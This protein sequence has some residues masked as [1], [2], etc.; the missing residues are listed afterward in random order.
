MWDI[1]TIHFADGFTF[2][3][4]SDD[5]TNIPLPS[6]TAIIMLPITENVTRYQ[7]YHGDFTT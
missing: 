2:M 5:E 4:T 6:I 1:H 7:F 3:T